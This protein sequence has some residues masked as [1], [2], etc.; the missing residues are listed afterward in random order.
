MPEI[1]D[2]APLSTWLDVGAVIVAVGLV[3]SSVIPSLVESTL[4]YVSPMQFEQDSALSAD[5]TAN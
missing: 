2:D 4:N 1:V 3:V 5:A